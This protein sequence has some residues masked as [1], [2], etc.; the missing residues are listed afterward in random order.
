MEEI[1]EQRKMRDSGNTRAQQG[2]W[3]GEV[4]IRAPKGELHLY[5]SASGIG[6]PGDTRHHHLPAIVPL[7]QKISPLTHRETNTVTTPVKPEALINSHYCF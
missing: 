2:G 6:M 3:R 1:K 4:F 7:T 5:N